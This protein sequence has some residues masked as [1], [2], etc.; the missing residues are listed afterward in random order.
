V[1]NGFS[2]TVSWLLTFVRMLARL[3][4]IKSNDNNKSLKQVIFM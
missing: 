2:S 1:G 4:M 3:L